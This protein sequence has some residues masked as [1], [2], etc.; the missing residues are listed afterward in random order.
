MTDTRDILTESMRKFLIGPWSEN[1]T[2]PKGNKP[3]EMYSSGI[4]FPKNATTD[5]SENETLG[6][7]SDETEGVH[8]SEPETDKFIRPSSIGIRT[9]IS[10]NV[11]KINVKISYARYAN[12]ENGVWCRRTVSESKSEHVVDLNKKSDI[13]PIYD[14]EGI[15]ES[16]ISWRIY[17]DGVLNLFLE[18]STEWVEPEPKKEISYEYA[19]NKNNS[20]SIFQPEIHIFGEGAGTFMP[21]EKDMQFFRNDEDEMFD[22][23]Y[24]DRKIFA[25]GYNCA[26]DW[27]RVEKP[28]FVKTEIFPIYTEKEI[29]KFS[30]G[31][32]DR[33]KKI[34]MY[35]IGCFENDLEDYQKNSKQI[36]KLLSP[37]IEGYKKWIDTQESDI[38]KIIS[39]EESLIAKNNID[40]CRRVLER[41]EEGIKILSNVSSDD[42]KKILKA[43]VIMNR[44]ML[45]QRI[46]F[47]YS[48][49]SFK[50]NQRLEW[51]RPTK[52][53][54]E[55]YP[56]QIAFIIMSI[57]GISN[58]ID[59]DND[60]A[61][62]I[63]FP[64]G[65]GKT[66]TYLGV[67]AMTIVLRRLRGQYEDGLGVSVIMRYT[68][69]LLTLQQFERASTLIC[70]LEYLRRKVPNSGLGTEPFL[71]GLWVGHTL[72]PNDH[73][74]SKESIT[75]QVTGSSDE[76]SGGSPWQNS[77]CPWCG[78]KITIGNYK[79]DAK[80]KW[81]MV[82]CS[83]TSGRCI[84]VGRREN[85]DPKKILPMV[86]VDTD[87]YSRCP[88]MV[89]AT[90]DKFA[91]MPFKE[92]I[93]N[94]FGKAGRK[95][96][97]HGFLTTK[98]KR[99]KSGRVRSNNIC[100]IDGEGNHR[101]GGG[102]VRYVRN[103]SPPDLII[104]D[105]LHLITGPLGTMV[106]L[107]ESAV[108]FLTSENLGGKKT[109][110]K[111]I[112][113]TATIKG[114]KEQVRKIFNKKDTVTFPPPGIQR[115]DSFFW[116]ETEN[117]GKK[118]VGVSFS[119][120]SAKYTL[121]KMYAS[122]LQETQRIRKLKS[123]SEIDSYWTLVG[124]YNSFRE[125][126]GGNRLIEDDVDSNMRFLANTIYNEPNTL[127]DIGT[128]ESGMEEM[129]GRK[130][131]REI[132]IVKNKLEKALPDKDVISIL[133][134]TNM[135]SVGVDID[136]LSLMTVNGQPK[137][138][139]EYIQVS[140]RMGRRKGNP[141]LIFTLYNPYKPRD[142]SHYENFIGYHSTIQK[143][144]EPS[145]VTPFSRL[146]Y[147]RAIHAV[148]IAMIRQSQYRLSQRGDAN[149]FEMEFARDAKEFLLERF[150]SV[151]QEDSNSNSLAEF[152]TTIDEFLEKWTEFID[153]VEKDEMLSDGVE[154]DNPYNLDPTIPQNPSILMIEFAKK[155][156]QDSDEFPKST[157]ES[158]R[159]VEQQI[160]LE[161]L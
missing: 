36:S 161:Y 31:E 86:T 97:L 123:D 122:L 68:L 108:D 110:P 81:T 11:N 77:Y 25:S 105:E 47:D 151:E 135:I 8:L 53:V 109:G 136:R 33:P 51:P 142:I 55:W 91:R 63:W 65:G 57:P 50:G 140:G 67:A 54:A 58:K 29:A 98:T 148:I 75:S 145:S 104:Q 30:Q 72:T 152:R 93:G 82:M 139:T 79:Y 158:L 115:S 96:E 5:E 111:I 156:G 35:E 41:M 12:D 40:G 38:E 94:I 132:S 74:S 106:G 157:P 2:L 45:F 44:A 113:S 23:L 133:L 84:F 48:L 17:D 107:Y 127:R 143:F 118:F 141:G 124:Y 15:E 10:K 150:Q 102:R 155:G 52:G 134:A 69:R 21:V 92:D 149:D 16:N 121:A 153:K 32:D 59:E 99:D 116:W 62:L 138:S 49:N 20:N 70:A 43:F 154:Y 160:E 129:T 90:V 34:D 6:T 19:F 66:E 159:D 137:D 80:T 71:I 126:A 95:C 101:E 13:I 114:V 103:M 128:Q 56:F 14:S 89:I 9:R 88:S 147:S 130:S 28:K 22:M 64:T 144:V 37:M 46:H 73:V 117:I 3:L 119:Q 39:E 61:D 112:T 125:L 60:I 27:E 4:L 87:I 26:A 78:H 42:E 76:Y 100:S 131:Q 120:K 24:K 1:E 146:S 83:N 85:P 7:G 18:N